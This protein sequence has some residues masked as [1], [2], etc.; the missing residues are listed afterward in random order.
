[1]RVK[2]KKTLWLWVVLASIVFF[3]SGISIGSI[4]A[5]HGELTH[6][7]VTALLVS[8]IFLYALGPFFT[9]PSLLS[10][11]QEEVI[12]DRMEFDE[13]EINEKTNEKINAVIRELQ[14]QQ[15]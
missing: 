11:I 8:A 5:Q 7:N 13:R 9:I 10:A 2:S 14:K 12:I 1:M 6:F 15:P 4:S 3:L